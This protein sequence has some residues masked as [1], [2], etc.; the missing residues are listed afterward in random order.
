MMH[1][2]KKERYCI[3]DHFY[4]TAMS[5]TSCHREMLANDEYVRLRDLEGQTFT[6]LYEQVLLQCKIFSTELNDRKNLKIKQLEQEIEN[7][8]TRIEE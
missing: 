6:K 3:V 7:L 4:H 5:T 1:I 2:A 8:K